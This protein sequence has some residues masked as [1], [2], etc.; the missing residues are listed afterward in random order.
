MSFSDDGYNNIEQ[1]AF[2]HKRALMCLMARKTFEEKRLR[3]KNC[4]EF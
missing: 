3:R 1:I 4:F 2:D